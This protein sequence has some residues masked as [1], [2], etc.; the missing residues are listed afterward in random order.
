MLL[1][2][3]QTRILHGGPQVFET[4]SL[5]GDDVQCSW[6]PIFEPL[7]SRQEDWCHLSLALRIKSLALAGGRSALDKVNVGFNCCCFDQQCFNHAR[8][9]QPRF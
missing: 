6:K 3:S 1:E 2:I 5:G 7:N 8:T 9:L 4:V